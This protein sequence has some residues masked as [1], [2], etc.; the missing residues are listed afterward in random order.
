MLGGLLNH[1]LARLARRADNQSEATAALRLIVDE[2]DEVAAILRVEEHTRHGDYRI[3]TDDIDEMLSDLPKLP[4]AM[5]SE[6]KDAL[7][8]TLSYDAWWNLSRSYQWLERVKRTAAE[9]AEPGEHDGVSYS[10]EEADQARLEFLEMLVTMSGGC[11]ERARE[12]ILELIVGNRRRY[13]QL[14]DEGW[15]SAGRGPERPVRDLVGK[16]GQ[17]LRLRRLQ[18]RSNMRHRRRLRSARREVERWR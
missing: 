9:P 4:D 13:R 6:H 14:R 7:A 1:R 17:V 18:V 16:P 10:Q 11:V 12:S 3:R 8:R 15:W 5:W 2:L